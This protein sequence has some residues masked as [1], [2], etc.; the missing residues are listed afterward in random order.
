MGYIIQQSRY[1]FHFEHC[2]LV[3]YQEIPSGTIQ[4]KYERQENNGYVWEQNNLLWQ[5]KTTT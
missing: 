1:S 3:R 5:Y 2:N 4:K